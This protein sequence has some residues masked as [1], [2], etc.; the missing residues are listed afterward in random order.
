MSSPPQAKVDCLP[1]YILLD[2][3]SSMR[4][5]E[6]TLNETPEKLYDELIMSPRISDFAHVSLISFNTSAHVVLEMTD[7]QQVTALPQLA[8]NGVTNFTDAFRLLRQRIEQDVPMLDAAGR[9]VL[10]PVAFVDR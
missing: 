6:A 9:A 8:C 4:Q 1:T 2:T 5:V 3:S 10:R 7:I